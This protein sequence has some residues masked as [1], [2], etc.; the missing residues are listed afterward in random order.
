VTAT[1]PSVREWP[2]PP[3]AWADVVYVTS[4]NPRTENPQSILDEIC[5]GFTAERMRSVHVELDRRRAIERVL[6]DA[7]PSD[8]VLSPA[9][10]TRTTRLSERP[11]TLRRRRGVHA[12][13]DGKSLAA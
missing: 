4:D 7:E 2:A 12:G 11:N 6:A 5:T 8:V 3:N 9:R 13:A 10:G 1:A